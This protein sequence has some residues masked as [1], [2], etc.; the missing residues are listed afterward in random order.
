MQFPLKR[1]TTASILG[2]SLW[3]A[4]SASGLAGESAPQ[5][6][7]APRVPEL[8]AKGV[9]L[10]LIG[11]SEFCSRL[12][13]GLSAFGQSQGLS[14]V[15]RA[16]LAANGTSRIVTDFKNGRATDY[17][18]VAGLGGAAG[19]PMT[20]AGDAYLPL[21]SLV[22]PAI[23]VGRALNVALTPAELRF[24]PQ[25]Q[26]GIDFLVIATNAAAL[27]PER[28]QKIAA[29]ARAS[30]TRLHVIWTGEAELVPQAASA[31][32]AGFS[33]ARAEAQAMAWL[34]AVTGG[35]FVNLGGPGN[36]CS[37]LL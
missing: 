13:T 14:D 34:A 12:A 29:V 20:A 7:Q 5:A 30:G 35:A 17:L 23:G 19:V 22:G 24:L 10:R 36:P 33:S 9:S 16:L 27:N 8:S 15:Q 31:G 3:L 26:R 37:D 11:K 6:P 28:I 1:L 4:A 21:A 18:S 2:I 32:A 25:A